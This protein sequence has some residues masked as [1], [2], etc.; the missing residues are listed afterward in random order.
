MYLAAMVHLDKLWAGTA[1]P[2]AP[3]T[4]EATAY[5]DVSTSFTETY[6]TD[7]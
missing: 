7:A 1:A 6:S 2:V 3:A 5:K 4:L